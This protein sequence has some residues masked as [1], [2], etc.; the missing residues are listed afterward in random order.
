[1]IVLDTNFLSELMRPQPDSQV[2]A[3]ANGL[4]PQAIAI[5]AMN[6]LE[7]INPWIAGLGEHP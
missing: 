6:G 2:M 7:L 3:W 4:N 5:T 1:V